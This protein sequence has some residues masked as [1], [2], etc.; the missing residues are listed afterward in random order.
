MH[1]HRKARKN[2]HALYIV[3]IYHDRYEEKWYIDVLLPL[4]SQIACFSINIILH[5]P[6]RELPYLTC[7]M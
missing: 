7:F 4:L 3:T 1:L 2:V 6:Y 5:G